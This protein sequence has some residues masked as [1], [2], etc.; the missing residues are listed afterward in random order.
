VRGEE[1][2]HWGP[3]ATGVEL[4]GAGADEGPGRPIKDLEARVAAA[5]KEAESH[6]TIA[7]GHVHDATSMFEDVYKDMPEHLRRQRRELGI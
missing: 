3:G 7:S 1:G 6:G 5:K 2:R 4:G